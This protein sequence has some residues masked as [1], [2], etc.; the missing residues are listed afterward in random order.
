M[1]IDLYIRGTVHGSTVLLETPPGLP[2]GQSV[3]VHLTANANPTTAIE[4]AFGTWSD[5]DDGLKAFLKQTR[6][7]RQMRPGTSE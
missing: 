1:S 7:D 6:Q 2:D 3:T 5:D 4:N